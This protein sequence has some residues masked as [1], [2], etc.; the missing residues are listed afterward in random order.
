M[1]VKARQTPAEAERRPHF[2]LASSAATT[3]LSIR[4]GK[5]ARFCRIFCLLT[6]LGA[7]GCEPRAPF[8]TD[9]AT[10]TRQLHRLIVVGMTEARAQAALEA[11]GF[12]LARL[13]SDTARNHLLVATCTRN[14]ATWQ[15]GLVIVDGRVAATTVN[16]LK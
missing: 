12:T 6:L 8:S 4:M 16:V 9:P 15:V 5:F 1:R 2:P 7:L 11:R 13:S 14:Q 10:A 3:S